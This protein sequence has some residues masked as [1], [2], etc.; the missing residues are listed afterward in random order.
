MKTFEHRQWHGEFDRPATVRACAAMKVG[1]AENC[2]CGPCRNFS[3][4]K[5]VPYPT[6]F[7]TLLDYLGIQPDREIEVYW[8]VYGKRHIDYQGWFY[9]VG[10]VQGEGMREIPGAGSFKY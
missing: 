4:Q 8:Y 5:P 7:L 9:F 1:G 6:E 10:Q 2:N 3:L